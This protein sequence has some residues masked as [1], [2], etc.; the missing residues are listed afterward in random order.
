MKQQKLSAEDGQVMVEYI[1]VCLMVALV[2]YLPIDN[3]PLFEMVI[4]GI[5]HMHNGYLAGMSTYAYPF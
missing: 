5:R 2:L 1:I 3:K 4:E